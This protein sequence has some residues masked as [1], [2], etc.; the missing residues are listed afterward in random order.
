VNNRGPV[1]AGVHDIEHV[2]PRFGKNPVGLIG[3]NRHK[4]NR[5]RET[6]EPVVIDDPTAQPI[7]GG[8]RL[9][10]CDLNLVTQPRQLRR[11]PDQLL[12]IRVVRGERVMTQEIESHRRSPSGHRSSGFA[13]V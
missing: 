12:G 4:F 1:S 7:A 5:V 13:E 10:T 9:T 11:R 6:I 8:I 2:G 3:R